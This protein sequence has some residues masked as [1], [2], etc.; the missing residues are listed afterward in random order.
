M[1]ALVALVALVAPPSGPAGFEGRRIAA[2]P[3]ARRGRRRRRGAHPLRGAQR[4]RGG[5]SPRSP[6][7]RDRVATRDSSPGAVKSSSAR[8]R[9]RPRRWV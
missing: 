6:V 3:A 7:A 4:M 2:P 5:F 9:G 1:A 8:G